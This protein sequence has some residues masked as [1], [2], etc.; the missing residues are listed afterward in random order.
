MTD[1]SPQSGQ[2]PVAGQ[3]QPGQPQ[4]GQP[5]PG[6]AQPGLAQ[7]GHYPTAGYPPQGYGPATGGYPPAPAPS[8]P[9]GGTGAAAVGAS[10]W[11]ALAS[12]VAMA[13]AVSLKEDGDNGWGRIGVWAGF[14]IA[15]A[16][17]TLLPTIGRQMN[18]T[19][20]RA[21]R[22]AAAGAG[23]LAAFWVLFVLPAISMNVSF[24]ATLGVAAGVGAAW[25]APGRPEP[26]GSTGRSGGETW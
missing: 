24:A 6:L 18:L 8:D 1:G 4:P 12:V 3:P 9:F 23:G 13:L 7:P 26:S 17:L 16:V 10:T 14:A 5:Q 22:G 19:A 15:A 2:S 21:W 20:V 25:L 11:L